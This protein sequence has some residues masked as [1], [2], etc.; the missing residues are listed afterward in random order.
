MHMCD[1]HPR[2]IPFQSHRGPG[3]RAVAWRKEMALLPPCG[4]SHF[5]LSAAGLGATSSCPG[6]N[7]GQSQFQTATH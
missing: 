2:P 5:E 6:D 7:M 4:T 1:L 3:L